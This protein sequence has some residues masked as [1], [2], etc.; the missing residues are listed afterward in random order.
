MFS[1]LQIISLWLLQMKYAISKTCKKHYSGNMSITRLN[2]NKEFERENQ[3]S[4]KISS[5]T[6]LLQG[7]KNPFGSMEH[8]NCPMPNNM[9]I[10]SEYF[11]FLM[12]SHALLNSKNYYLNFI[13]WCKFKKKRVKSHVMLIYFSAKQLKRFF[14]LLILLLFVLFIKFIKKLLVM[15]KC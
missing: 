15:L 11:L 3:Q 9:N 8:L 12:V 7:A 5:T 4:S 13:N 1:G 2:A 14:V 6:S 10:N